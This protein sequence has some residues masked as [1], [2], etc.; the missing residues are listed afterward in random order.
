MKNLIN[1]GSGRFPI[2]RR[3]TVPLHRLGLTS[4][5]VR[6]LV[7]IPE[8]R[9]ISNVAVVIGLI[10]LFIPWLSLDGHVGPRSGVGLMTYA[11]HGND[12]LV[13]WRISPLAAAALMV[14]PFTVAATVCLT[15]LNATR[16]ECRLDAPVFTMAGVLL[17]LR[18]T[19][20]VLSNRMET[21]G[22]FALPEWGLVIL[23]AATLVVITVG[24][25][26]RFRRCMKP[27]RSSP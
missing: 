17:L 12:R 11:L 14:I 22:P 23:L 20:P 2:N 5:A 18:L 7:S 21:V 4:D 24:V 3:L 25:G 10:S 8:A 16:R 27:W 1:G 13:M 26:E 19:P 15:A 6:R 9:T